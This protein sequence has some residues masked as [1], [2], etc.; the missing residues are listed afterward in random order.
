MANRF[1][2]KLYMQTKIKYIDGQLRLTSNDDGT[3][4]SDYHKTK[5]RPEDL[6]EWY[7][8]GRFYKQWGY[9]STQGIV[10]MIYHPNLH[11]N[12]FLKDD[13]LYISYKEKITPVTIQEKNEKQWMYERYKGYDEIVCG[14]EIIDILKGARKYSNY[15]ISFIV[16]QI[17]DKQK[18]LRVTFPDQFGEEIWKYDI[19]SVFSEDI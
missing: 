13:F 6:P 18:W 14:N 15:D 11:A 10:D 7:L 1:K 2:N 17:S 19:N 3:L 9:M 4:F 16:K 5:I 8:F 12:H